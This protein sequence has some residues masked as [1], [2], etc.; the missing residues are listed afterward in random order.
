MQPRLEL[1]HFVGVGAVGVGADAPRLPSIREVKQP[2]HRQR[3][4][5]DDESEGNGYPGRNDR[6]PRDG[7]E[8]PCG[9]P[10][11]L[12]AGAAETGPYEYVE[13]AGQGT[14]HAEAV[15]AQPDAEFVVL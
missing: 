5:E 1:L 14:S 3:D 11:G 12:I 15:D 10:Q 4:D 7:P 13:G 9:E 2:D 8:R 6:E